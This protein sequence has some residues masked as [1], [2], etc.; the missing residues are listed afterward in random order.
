M[1]RVASALI[2]VGMVPLVQVLLDP[3]GHTATRFTFFGTPCL[4]AGIGLY[5]LVRLRGRVE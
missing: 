3:T 5:L 4:V 2:L 1:I